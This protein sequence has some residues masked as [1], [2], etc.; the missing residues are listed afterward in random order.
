MIT[1]SEKLT[2]TIS[3]YFDVWFVTSDVIP[4][5]RIYRCRFATGGKLII[6][7]TLF[8]IIYLSE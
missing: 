4:T 7:Q 3:N 8:V 5:V 1:L 2:L 6:V